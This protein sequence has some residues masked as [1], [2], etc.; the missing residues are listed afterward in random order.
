MSFADVRHFTEG[1]ARVQKAEAEVELAR[2]ESWAKLM[3]ACAKIAGG[4]RVRG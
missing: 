3:I 2:D 4:V 1:L